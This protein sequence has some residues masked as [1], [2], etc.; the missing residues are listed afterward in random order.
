[1]LFSYFDKISL[2]GSQNWTFEILKL[3]AAKEGR[4]ITA[5]DHFKLARH[6]QNP[7]AI[8]PLLRHSGINDRWIIKPA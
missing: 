4:I 1:M 2:L 7:K 8:K 5:R 3:A 6:H